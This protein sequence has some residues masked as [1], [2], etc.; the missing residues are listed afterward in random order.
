M[1]SIFQIKERI[2]V[3][4]E[5]QVLEFDFNG[6]C[7]SSAKTSGQVIDS[8]IFDRYLVLRKYNTLF[9]WDVQSFSQAFEVEIPFKVST[10]CFYAGTINLEINSLGK[11]WFANLDDNT[12][13]IYSPI[14]I[15]K[16]LVSLEAEKKIPAHSDSITYLLSFGGKCWSTSIDCTMKI[17]NS[18][19]QV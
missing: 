7:Y 18:G 2:Y 16:L 5:Q 8:Y 14:M 10:L 17:W 9:F 15:E 19:T 4:V 13:T 1:S 3:C 12:I 6:R 11:F